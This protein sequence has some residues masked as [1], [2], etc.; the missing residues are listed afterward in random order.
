MERIESLERGQRGLERFIL[1]LYT[2]Y[3]IN[4]FISALRMHWGNWEMVIL[5]VVMT[6]SWF[7]FKVSYKTYQ[8]RVLSTAVM[9]QTSVFIYAVNSENVSSVLTTLLVFAVMLG[10]YGVAEV[11]YVAA[12]ASVMILMYYAFWTDIIR[13]QSIQEVPQVAVQIINIF[14]VEY[15]V[16]IWVKKRSES[17]EQLMQVIAGL[18]EAEQ[19]K[20]DFLANVSHELRTPINTIYGMSEIVLQSEDPQQM[21]EDVYDIQVAGRNL[22]TVVSDILDFSELQSGKMEIEEETYNI[23]STINDV[24]NMTVA[25]KQDKPIELVVDCDAELPRVLYG[26][27]KKIRRVIMNLVR[28]A[29]K[30]TNSGCVTISFAMRREE[31]GINLIVT[32]K[33]TGIGMDEVAL[34]KLF[35]S[36]NQVDAKRNRQE[37]GVGLGMAISKAIVQKMGG[38]IT[39]KSKFGKGTTMKVVIPQRVVEEQPI[40]NI[41]NKEKLY[42]AV[43][44]NMEQFETM[45]VRDEYTDI[46]KHMIEQIQVRSHMCRNLAELKRRQEKESFTHIFISRQEYM[47]DPEYFDVL[48]KHT[49]VIAVIDRLN[50]KLIANENILRVFKPFYVLPIVNILNDNFSTHKETYVVRPTRFVAPDV[51]VLVVDDN[52][53]NIKVIQGLLEKY[54]IRVTAAESGTEALSKIE[55]MDYDFVF[56]DHMMPEMDGIETLHN[57]RKKVGTYYSKVPVIA[58]TANA[59]AGMREMFLSE[60][61]ADFVEKPVELSVLERVLMRNLPENKLIRV[62]EDAQAEPEVSGAGPMMLGDELVV[63]DL[64]V[65]KGIIYCGGRKQYLEILSLYDQNGAETLEKL[66]QLFGDRAWKNYII[67]VHAVKSTMLSIGA[68]KLSEMAKNL[69]LSGKSGKFDYILAH[70]QLMMKEYRRVLQLLHDFLHHGE[71]DEEQAAELD[72][73]ELSDERFDQMA[74]DMEDAMYALDGARML[75]ILEEMQKYQYHGTPL[76]PSVAPLRRKIE[77]SDYMSAVENILK[78]KN[79]IKSGRGGEV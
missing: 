42:V 40:T 51:H 9:M 13:F 1:I 16:Y 24:I 75:E 57:I 3:N 58:L 60:G 8:F 15:L 19:S 39:V 59:V 50:D 62:S 12:T 61:F 76:K 37:G 23:T 29:I 48:S 6:I 68:E 28:N 73:P 41:Q 33:D 30:F 27:E 47:E 65:E 35:T 78:I 36:F 20:N 70:H 38:V 10:L 34:E 74:I 69:E 52:I 49:C 66:D 11:S 79:R 54:Q 22:M 63:G 44:V 21:K 64:N 46:I 77:M 31:Y 5:A 26:D 55:T 72:L 32:V 14:V 71:S 67:T 56:M 18:Q 7:M 4:M 43:Y 25:D 2:I 17:S 53:M 45:A